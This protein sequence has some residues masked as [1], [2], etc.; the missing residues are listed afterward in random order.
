MV[1]P[2]GGGGGGGRSDGGGDRSVDFHT[3]DGLTWTGETCGCG[4]IPGKTGAGRLGALGAVGRD[5]G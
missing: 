3:P 5:G 2:V 1:R 4:S